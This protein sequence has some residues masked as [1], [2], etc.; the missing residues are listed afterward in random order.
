MAQY[1][2]YITSSA[3]GSIHPDQKT[4]P[5]TLSSFPQTIKDKISGSSAVGVGFQTSSNFTGE[6]LN[7]IISSPFVSPTTPTTDKIRIISQ[8]TQG[9]TLS[10]YFRIEKANAVD[11]NSDTNQL[12][13]IFSQ[14]NQINKDIIG[15]F[16]VISIVL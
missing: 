11:Y 10:P 6:T 1:Q 4:F 13:I 14:T 8:Q 3:L 16:G 15:Q 9:D 5:F 12:N 7:R 2:S